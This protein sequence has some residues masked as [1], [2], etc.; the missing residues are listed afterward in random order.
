MFLHNL[1]MLFIENVIPS[2]YVVILY[3]PSNNHR[4]NIP[5]SQFPIMS[6]I[7]QFN[8]SPTRLLSLR[9]F[10][11]PSPSRASPCMS[12]ACGSAP[13]LNKSSHTSRCP[14]LA[15]AINGVL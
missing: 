12:T 4:N 7:L 5:H 2:S 14:C 9:W 8:I 3:P 13:F 1:S 15:A 11:T 6:L 10:S